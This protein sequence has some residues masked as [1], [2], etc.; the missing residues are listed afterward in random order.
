MSHNSDYTNQV[1]DMF[2][3]VNYDVVK[4]IVEK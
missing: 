4:L 1:E 3:A 2:G